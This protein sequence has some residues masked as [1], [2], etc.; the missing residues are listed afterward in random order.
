M[1]S[2]SDRL[3]ASREQ[4]E[5]IKKEMNNQGKII[6]NDAIKELFETANGKLEAIGWTQ[7]TPYFADGSPCVFGVNEIY[8]IESGIK[9][10]GIPSSV[11]DFEDDENYVQIDLDEPSAYVRKAAQNPKDKWDE[12]YKKQVER[13]D[14]SPNHEFNSA[15]AEVSKFI[16]NNPEIMQEIY[17]DH[18][19]VVITYQDGEVS[20]D[21]E[22]YEHD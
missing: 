13:W 8:F 3:A 17:G 7:Y 14:N 15:C 22:E 6:L 5:K 1:S 2:L 12:R 20:V 16:S 10:H 4:I 9:E 18:C 21:V 11:Y 19:R